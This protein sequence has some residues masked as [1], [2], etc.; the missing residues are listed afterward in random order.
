[1]RDLLQSFESTP[2][3]RMQCTSIG[4]KGSYN[5][6]YYSCERTLP[7]KSDGYNLC[8]SKLAMQKTDISVMKQ[9]KYFDKIILK[10]SLS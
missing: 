5:M 3:P 8:T 7:I 9:I 6:K 4:E 10:F 2:I 1:M